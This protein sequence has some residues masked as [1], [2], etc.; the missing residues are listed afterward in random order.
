MVGYG[1]LEDNIHSANESF[2][3]EHFQK[4]IECSALLYDEFAA[5]KK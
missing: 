3:L 2:R 5:V 1:L 4:G